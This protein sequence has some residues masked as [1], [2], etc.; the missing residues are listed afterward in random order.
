M[1]LE[2]VD[3]FVVPRGV[4]HMPT[5]NAGEVAEIFTIERAETVI[6]GDRRG[7]REGEG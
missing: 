1:V 6:T 5:T 2:A 7:K 3:L 4:R